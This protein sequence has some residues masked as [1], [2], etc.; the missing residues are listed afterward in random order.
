MVAFCCRKSVSM[1]GAFAELF[2]AAIHPWFA[3]HAGGCL[4]SLRCA[5]GI[6][7]AVLP[8]FA[9]I[10]ARPAKLAKRL[11][12]EGTTRRVRSASSAAGEYSTY[13]CDAFMRAS[14][15]DTE[16]WRMAA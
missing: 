2:S 7:R 3:R 12:M 9:G 6:R 10:G 11:R 13:L 16:T 5:A 15:R 14:H 4:E 8:F 1:L